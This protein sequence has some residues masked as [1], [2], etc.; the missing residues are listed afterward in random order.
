MSMI[1]VGKTEIQLVVYKLDGHIYG[2][3]ISNVREMIDLQPL[4]PVSEMPEC[5]EGTI[6]VREH[7]IPVVDLRK[8]F[9]LPKIGHLPNNRI[10]VVNCHDREVGIIVDSVN[11]LLIVSA[12]SIKPLDFLFIGEHLEHLS[13]VVRLNEKVVILM[14]MN[15]I[16]SRADIEKFRAQ[17]NIT[18]KICC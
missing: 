15:T 9:H 11:E 12:E 3:D 7:S 14:D 2:L 5:F 10:L 17:N 13:G 18:D 8:R 16:V 4:V 1:A 6:K